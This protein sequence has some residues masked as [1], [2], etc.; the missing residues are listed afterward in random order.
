MNSLL[1]ENLVVL[2][3]ANN[4][5][6]DV[7]HGINLIKEYSKVCKKYPQFNYAFKLQYRHLDSFIH[8]DFKERFDL[9]YIKRFQETR[10]NE[11]DFD[12]LIN[13]IKDNKNFAMVT[14]FDNES[15]NLIKKQP[16]DIV[17]I[18]SCS[19]GDWPLLESA[20]QLDLPII[21]STAGANLE[22]IDNVIS[23]FSNRD[24]DFAIM[25]CVAQYPT[26]DKNMNLSQ[27]DFLKKRYSDVRVGFSTHE[28]PGSTDMI[29][30][31]ISKGADIFEKHIALPT[32]EYPINKYSVDLNQF[33]DWLKAASFAQN[34]CGEGNKR[35]LDNKDEQKSLKSLQRGVFF[36]ASLDTG[37]VVTPADVYFAF[38]SEEDQY[39]ANDF[40]K[41]SMF[42]LT[43]N[44]TKNQSLSRKNSKNINSRKNLEKIVNQ[45]KKIVS[46]ADI[47]LPNKIILEISHHYGIDKFDKFGMCIFTLINRT[48]CKKLLICFAGQNHPEQ[49]HTKKEETFRLLYGDASLILDGKESILNPGDIVT[50]EKEVRH[51]FSSKSGCIIEEI[52][53]THF[54]DDSFYS[55]DAIN[56]NMDRKTHVTF[57]SNS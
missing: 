4:H 31:A 46:D 30:M 9:G 2:E 47:K 38:P 22:T 16:I 55:D 6:G 3:I 34:V 44:V 23:F 51:E 1:P 40:S 50:V 19:F 49:Y 56:K 36:K 20:A 15:Y 28:D 32:E 54:K 57:F 29:K 45:V 21:A 12:L 5:M 17:K 42:T 13:C 24:K 8:E 52:S 41:Y 35:V 11:E 43:K 25:H 48:Y 10:L 18:A 39:T 53:D 27:I 7:Q 14:A 37:H 33:E 26:P